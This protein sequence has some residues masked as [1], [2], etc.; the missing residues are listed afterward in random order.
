V[1]DDGAE[2]RALLTSTPSENTESRAYRKQFSRGR[3]QDRK[4]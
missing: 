4:D 3:E 2:I 1:I